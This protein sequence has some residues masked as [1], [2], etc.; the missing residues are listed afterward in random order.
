MGQ[1]G[2]SQVSIVLQGGGVEGVQGGREG[3]ASGS[4]QLTSPSPH[5]SLCP[6]RACAVTYSNQGSWGSWTQRERELPLLCEQKPSQKG[7]PVGAGWRAARKCG[8]R[9]SL[10]KER[11]HSHRE[12]TVT[13]PTVPSG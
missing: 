4:G 5:L 7:G 1:M 2:R 9:G 12:G 11:R 13:F 6:T 8:R 3:A 10:R